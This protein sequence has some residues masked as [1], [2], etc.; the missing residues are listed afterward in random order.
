MTGAMLPPML[1]PSLSSCA[2]TTSA[3]ASLGT[4]IPRS[5]M[6]TTMK[7]VAP[8]VRMM[9]SVERAAPNRSADRPACETNN[10]RR[11]LQ[12]S[13]RSLPRPSS[14]CKDEAVA[15]ETHGLR[16]FGWIACGRCQRWPSR[17][18]VAGKRPEPSAQTAPMMRHGGPLLEQRSRAAARA[19]SSSRRHIIDHPVSSEIAT[20]PQWGPKK[21]ST[22]A[23]SSDP[24][25]P[26][27][28]AIAVRLDF[29]FQAMPQCFKS[30]E[31]AIEA[32]G[33]GRGRPRKLESRRIV[34]W[35]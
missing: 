13:L 9:S 30:F 28:S 14:W 27:A 7:R 10:R 23:Q 26:F 32:Q 19:C 25:R 15:S 21:L 34:G 22:N 8:D 5:A 29:S 3:T 35:L 33:P 11:P 4:E 17:V 24:H 2:T 6:T 31:S 20:A 18:G 16:D 1:P 12:P